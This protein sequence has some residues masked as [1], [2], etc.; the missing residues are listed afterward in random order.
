[1][2]RFNR[3]LALVASVLALISCQSEENSY[4]LIPY[5]NHIEQIP[6]RFSF[7]KGTQIFVSPECG[8][9][10]TGVLQQFADQ[11]QKT[12]G[13]ELKFADEERNN[14]IVVKA[15]PDLADE[16]YRLNIGKSKIEIAAATPNGVRF[17]LQTVKQLL[18][19]AVYGDTLATGA[20]WSVP[21]AAIDDAPRFGYRGL[22]LDV[23]R[24]FFSTDEV[25]RILN[26]MAVHKLNTMH[27][28]LTDDQG[29]RVEIKKYPRLTEVGSMR[30]KTMIAKEWDNYDNT[31]YGGFYTQDELRDIV[32]YA[33]D[34]G[35]TIIPEI[36]LPGHMMAALAS[37]PELGCTGG[38]YEVSGQWGIRD[39]VLCAG[40][41]KTFEFIEN[42]LLEVMD[43]FPSK[44][45]HIGGD[46]C[47]KLRWEKCPACQAR[48]KQLGL[49]DDEHGTAEHYLQGYVTE[50]VEKFLND[51]GREMI[52]WDEIMEGG[53]ST[54]A[55]VMS[56]RGVSNGVEAA[57]QGHDV[58]MTPTSPLYFDY[59]QSRDTQSEPLAI[60]G[61]NPVDLV[62]K[63]NPVPEELTEEEA[64]HILGTQANVWTEY[65]PTNDQLE[66][67]ILPRLAAL[68][69]VQWDQLENKD[70]DRFLNHIGHILE[71]YN[72]MGL[73]YAKHLFEV[74]GEY[75]VNDSKNCIEAT[76]R[77]Q[78][79]API[80]YTLDG[81]EPT[82]ASTLYTGPIEI[83]TDADT[84]T[85]KAIVVRDQVKTR[86]LVRPFS[87]NKATGHL[88]ELKDAPSPKYTFGGASVLTDGIHGDFN[89]SN[90][91]WL[92]FI[93]TP[94]D[95]T[96]DLGDTQ[97]VSSV[98][99][100]SLVQY[101][102]Y[103][104]PPTKITVYAADG[105]NPMTEIG[106]LEIPVAPKQDADGV[107]QYTCEFP[108]VPASKIRVVVETTGQIPAWHGAHGEK[109]WLFV[110]EISIN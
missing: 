25:K 98:K 33:A 36:D 65:M 103:I 90:G 37:Y 16:A 23:A 109:G 60:G 82:T 77:T 95:A 32:K 57:K 91:C 27:W 69:E 2:K 30:S 48:I 94:L 78:G 38:P 108:S 87:F 31:P 44:Y 35:I 106:K 89:Y 50:R 51:H 40:K 9:E 64:K 8:D 104:F 66:Y 28:H 99:V 41:D 96:I 21:C 105:D 45:I 79:D 24:H 53:L 70:Y 52:G 14:A 71:I 4:D 73:N 39:D 110:D 107:R 19:A 42:V 62:Y 13:M 74:E 12:S 26:V 101:S 83:S 54:H 11:F 84:C 88:A 59:Y 15:N 75:T 49:K 56:W 58:I 67:M 1:M 76:L 6:G 92:G 34:L 22:H 5:P 7:D 43:I 18:P 10:V 72:A 81:T 47:P 46:E 20:N 68:S 29:W 86:T 93:D 61:Y 55:T 3:Y 17:A 97:S 85:L 63:F 102:E 80:Y 100:G